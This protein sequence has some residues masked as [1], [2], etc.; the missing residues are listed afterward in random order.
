MGR[1]AAAAKAAAKETDELFKADIAK[2]T[3]IDTAKLDEL[4]PDKNDRR[5][6]TKLVSKLRASTAKNH[7]RT[8]LKAF[9]LVASAA[10]IKVAKKILL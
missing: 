6:V 1:F 7:S 5:A 4:F 10:A 9:T 3:T 8:A 2:L